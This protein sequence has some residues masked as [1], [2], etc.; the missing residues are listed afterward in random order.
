[1]QREQYVLELGF[2]KSSDMFVEK[3]EILYGLNKEYSWK[4]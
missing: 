1:M 2:M 4:K 3:W